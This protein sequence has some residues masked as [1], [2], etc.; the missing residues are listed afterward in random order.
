MNSPT[1]ALDTAGPALDRFLANTPGSAAL[2]ARARNVMPGGSSRS[3]AFYRPYPAVFK[4]GDG[5]YLWDVDD[6]RYVDL[7]YNGLSLIHGHAYR[8]VE[9]AVI[10]AMPQGT[11]WIGSSE[12][13]IAYAEDLCARIPS[14]DL[15]RF[16]NTGTEATMLGVK[17]A[18]KV[19][20]RPMVLKSWGAY[21]GSYDDLEAGLYGNSDFPGRTA[22]ARFGD[23]ESYERAF[24]EHGDRIAALIIEPVLLTFRVVSPPKDFLAQICELAR[25]NGSVVVLDDCLMF[26]LAYGGS[27]EKYGFEPDLT[28]LGKFIG[29]GLPMG[30]VAGKR[31][32]MEALDPY[33]ETRL[34]HGGSFNGNPLAAT[35]GRIS[36]A[37][38]TREKITAMDDRA[39]RL[40]EALR[41]K[42]T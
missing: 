36:L 1:T 37:D 20:D 39:E 22:L 7:T 15:V 34:Y 33:G 12:Q 28:C 27:A 29:G 14:A 3:H 26:R 17:V 21:H 40:R 23:I 25:Q 38:L 41:R 30:V 9:R 18:R 5:P 24:A 42:A 11:A 2:M 8:P 13:Q 10:E 35:A 4:S 16:T 6:N 31:E 19:T 32:F